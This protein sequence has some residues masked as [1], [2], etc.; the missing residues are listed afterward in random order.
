LSGSELGEINGETAP[1]T[2]GKPGVI[3]ALLACVFLLAAVDTVL[4]RRAQ[5]HWSNEPRLFLQTLVLWACLAG[6]AL[7]PAYAIRYLLRRS[8]PLLGSLFWCLAFPIASHRVLDSFTSF[9]GDTVGLRSPWPWLGVLG[10][11]LVCLLTAFVFVRFLLSGQNARRGALLSLLGVSSL[12]GFLLPLQD[13]FLVEGDA[14]GKP[15]LLLLVWD[16][17][18]AKS[19]TAFDEDALR[20]SPYLTELASQGTTFES[21]RSVSCFTFTSHLSMLTGVYPSEHGAWIL[22]LNYD[23]TRA[24]HVAALLQREGYRTGAFVGTDVLAGHT[25][26]NY[27]FETYDDI[28]DPPVT[29]TSAWGLVHD[30]QSI[31]AAH[32][33]LFE[34]NG[35]PHWIQ[36]FQRPADD[37]LSAAKRWIRNG[38]K[39][40]WFCMINMYDAH[41]PYLPSPDATAEFVGEYA[42]PV[43]GFSYRSTGLPKGYVM[44]AEDQRHLTELYGAEIF[45]LDAKVGA[46]LEELAVAESNTAIV[47]TADHGEAFG[48]GGS[49]GHH[50]IFEPQVRVPLLIVPPPGG[51]AHAL[52]FGVRVDKMTS[53]IDI[54][55]TLLGLA[56]VAVPKGMRGIDLARTPLTDNR[57]LLLEDR[58]HKNAKDSHFGIYR[59]GFKY[60]RTGVG[61]HVQ[62][63]LFELAHDPNGE[64]DVSDDYP[65]LTQELATLLDDL[66]A[67]WN[68]DEGLQV[69]DDGNLDGLGALGYL[70]D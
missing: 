45:E 62:G 69:A 25:G 34:F 37:S 11:G 3:H 50:D 33:P 66:R 12:C 22:N 44:N 6:L 53:G 42:G 65:E 30:L 1:D 10:A 43:N 48:E 18:R 49:F 19:L 27:G 47:V 7:L 64:F 67:Q 4:V 59:D 9:G 70:E 40:P 15:N 29:Y 16:T 68:G 41:W 56:G 31:A 51:E 54:A 35:R 2:L 55:P 8:V 5:S 17:V 36:D 38:D 23:P 52:G 21:A 26:M 24:D 60:T 14:T 13:E 28:V 63:F 20:V 61:Q 39:R 46:F 58:D 57:V 32:I